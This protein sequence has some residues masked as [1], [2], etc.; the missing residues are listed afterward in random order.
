MKTFRIFTTLLMMPLCFCTTKEKTKIEETTQT[1]AKT[2]TA[3]VIAPLLENKSE[4]DFIGFVVSKEKTGNSQIFSLYDSNQNVSTF[5]FAKP[6]TT[7]EPFAWHPDYYLLVF[8]CVGKTDKGYKVIS[9]EKTQDIK[10]IRLDDS[11]FKFQTK[12]EHILTAFSV[13]FNSAKNPIKKEASD[14]AAALPYDK[15]EFY[16]PVKIDGDWLQVKWGGDANPETGWIRW[17]KNNQMII[18]LFYFT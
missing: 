11:N 16:M 13:E 15:E 10:Y 8:R 3:D 12:A 18:E 5:S 4:S 2:K 1:V 6:L 7:I 14:N 9:N 17:Q